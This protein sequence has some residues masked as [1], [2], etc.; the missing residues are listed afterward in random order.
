MDHQSLFIQLQELI[1]RGQTEYEN[2]SFQVPTSNYYRP[3]LYDRELDLI[4]EGPILIDLEGRFD[5]ELSFRSYDDYD[6]PLVV[7]YD[8]GE[9]E[10]FL[11]ICQHRGARIVEEKEGTRKTFTCPYHSWCYNKKGELTAIPE[12][13]A[14]PHIKKG[15]SLSEFRVEKAFGGLWLHTKKDSPSIQ[16]FIGD[17]ALDF[18]AAAQRYSQAYKV[19]EIEY[20][21][22]WKFVVDAVLESYHI[23]TL[24]HKTFSRV[25]HG[26]LGLHQV[27]GLHSRN[28]YPFKNLRNIELA[29]SSDDLFNCASLVYHLFPNVIFSIQPEFAVY[30]SV[31][32]ISPGSCKVISR[33]LIPEHTDIEAAERGMALTLQ[34]IQE[35]HSLLSKV[36]EN[37]R[38]VPE[39]PYNFGR[40]EHML[41]RFHH[42]L[43][44]NIEKLD[45]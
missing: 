43:K 1:A 6:L 3:D 26:N 45:F 24:H 8:K 14:F 16:E 32:P 36:G 11:N 37:M 39:T 17:L 2:F 31:V 23:K 20:P 42:N 34:G 28:L 38:N 22:N 40:N 12:E 35:D 13:E 15:R 7:S 21:L 18:A 27:F 9:F 5:K 44:E 25:L 33:Y 29:R 41:A 30:F 19:T 10:A 4:K